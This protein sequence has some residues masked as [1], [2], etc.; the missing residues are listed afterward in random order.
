MT[1]WLNWTEQLLNVD[2]ILKNRTITLPTKIHLVKAMVF[3]V[4]MCGC[5]SWAIKKAEHQRIDGFKLWCWRR[6][7]RVPWTAR[8][9][10]LDNHWKDWCWS[11]SSNTLAT[12]WEDPTH[13]KDLDTGKDWG[14][15]EKAATKDEMV[16][17]H[18]WH[19]AHSLSKLQEILQDKKPGMLQSLGSQSQI[20]LS[21]WTKTVKKLVTKLK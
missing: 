20:W 8:K 6:L 19:K 15:E 12:L 4:V 7:L 1:E 14:Q 17:S 2:S 10:T 18:V 5:E 21:A 9:S 11:W 13:L 3:P 16:G